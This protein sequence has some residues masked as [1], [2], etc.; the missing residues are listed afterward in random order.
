MVPNMVPNMARRLAVTVATF[1]I[2]GSAF[3]RTGALKLIPNDAVSVG[4]IRVADM[5]N[6][7]LSST[8]FQQT[9]RISSHGDGQMFLEDAGLQPAKD[10]DLVVVAT[11]P[12][13]NLGTEAEVLVAVDGRFN[14][15]RLSAA[16]VK[17]GAVARNGYFVLPEK[18]ASQGKRGVVAFPDGS[19]ALIGSESAVAQALESRATGGTTFLTASGLG[20]EVA[21]ID[22]HATAWAVVDVPRA[23]RLAHVPQVGS[24]SQ[25]GQALQSAMKSVSTLVMW[26]TDAGDSLKFGGIGVAH[27]EETLQLLEDTIRGG[28][29]AMRLA[30]QDNSPELVSVLRKFEVSHTADTVQVTGSIPADMLKSFIAKH[31]MEEKHHMETK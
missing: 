19:L 25:Q 21:R 2:A 22:K 29:A 12:A 17:R 16:L 18:E 10:V 27:D 24:H 31:H 4:V 28:L 5:R 15:D 8:L 26:A 30:S 9:D 13:Q 11:S 14:V 7:P 6:S 20:R 3:A 23:A 1:A